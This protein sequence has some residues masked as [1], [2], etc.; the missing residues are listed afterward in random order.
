[1]KWRRFICGA[2]AGFAFFAAPG[3]A[4]DAEKADAIVSWPT[5]SLFSER[6][7]AC[8]AFTWLPSANSSTCSRVIF[9][10]FAISSA[11]MPCPV[12]AYFAVNS[13]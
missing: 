9:H 2:M 6:E 4:V 12:S 10:F 7:R 1:M 8:L 13:G 11:A 5:S 3:A